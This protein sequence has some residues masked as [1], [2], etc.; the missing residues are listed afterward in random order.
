[1]HAESIVEQ[2]KSVLSLSLSLS[3][4]VLSSSFHF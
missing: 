2:Y 4:I 3:T 1:M